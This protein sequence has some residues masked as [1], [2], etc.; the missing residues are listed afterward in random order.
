MSEM[1][2]MNE[3]IDELITVRDWLRWTVSRFNA[4]ELFFCHGTYNA[5]DEAVWMLLSALELPRDRLEPL[6]DARVLTSERRRLFELVERRVEQRVPMAY[7]LHE[8]WLGPLQF[9]VDNRTIV[10][11]SY[12]IELLEDSFSPWV[13]DADAVGSALD[14]CTGSGCLA[15]LLAQVF[16]QAQIDAID[17]SAAA[18]EVAQRNVA[19]Y[20]LEDRVSLLQ[21]DLFAAVPDKRY[22]VIICNPPYVTTQAMAE[23]PEEYRHEPAL[24][25]AAGDDGLDLVRRILRAAHRHLNPGGVIAVEVGHNRALVEEAFPH[26]PAIWLDSGRSADKVFLL[27]DGDLPC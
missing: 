27:R 2:E 6:L 8:A 5:W 7:L 10:P 25:L 19:D 26:L 9:Y 24:A 16:P 22:D 4:S 13:E 20:G 23:L 1:N 14:M 17:L 12:F 3:I 11:R 18:L 21:S 15:I